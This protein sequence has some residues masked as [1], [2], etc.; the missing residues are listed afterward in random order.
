MCSLNLLSS[1]GLYTILQHNNQQLLRAHPHTTLCNLPVLA[2]LML[3]QAHHV[4]KIII[5]I[6][7]TGQQTQHN[8]SCSFESQIVPAMSA[9]GLIIPWHIVVPTIK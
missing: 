4:V 5:L 7:L 1:C 2:H 3:K 9:S 6:S 8:V